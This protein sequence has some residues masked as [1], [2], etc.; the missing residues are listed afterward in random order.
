MAQR[1]WEILKQR[2]VSL[3][4]ADVFLTKS[5]KE[6]RASGPQTGD[7]SSPHKRR[8]LNSA[9]PCIPHTLDSLQS[10]QNNLHDC[11]SNKRKRRVLE[12]SSRSETS[13]SKDAPPRVFKKCILRGLAQ[14]L[15]LYLNHPEFGTKLFLSHFIMSFVPE[16]GGVWVS[17]RK[18]RS[19]HDRGFIYDAEKLGVIC[20]KIDLE[21]LVFCPS[22]GSTLL[23]EVTS[24]QKDG[25]QALVFGA[26]FCQIPASQFTEGSKLLSKTVETQNKETTERKQDDDQDDQLNA[27]DKIIQITDPAKPNAPPKEIGVGSPIKFM[28]LR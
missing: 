7:A 28:L 20:F 15:P 19:T 16:L 21:V 12:S 14:L 27:S 3:D 1:P 24:I 26:W 8:R 22:P 2:P 23:G 9:I 18:V 10:L 6:L 5:I 25:M 11:V 13:S 17:F 4:E